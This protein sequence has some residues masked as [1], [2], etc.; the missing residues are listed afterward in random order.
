MSLLGVLVGVQVTRFLPLRVIHR[1]AGVLFLLFG[2]GILYQ[3][4]RSFSFLNRA[5]VLVH[6]FFTESYRTSVARTRGLR[7][8]MFSR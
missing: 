5:D 6:A 7:S 2:V 3:A 1:I 4:W 8:V